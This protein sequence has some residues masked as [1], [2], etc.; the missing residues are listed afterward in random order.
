M[1]EKNILD[2]I[3]CQLVQGGQSYEFYKLLVK[4]G[5]F[6]KPP[7]L[8]QTLIVA[9]SLG[10]QSLNTCCSIGIGAHV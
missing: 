6:V 3:W 4:G 10:P 9:L 7:Y 2:E 1:A 5:L 8:V